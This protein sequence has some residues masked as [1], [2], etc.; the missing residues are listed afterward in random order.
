[1]GITGDDKLLVDRLTI[2]LD[3][4][5]NGVQ[6]VKPWHIN[7]DCETSDAVVI[8]TSEYSG[9]ITPFA[10]TKAVLVSGGKAAQITSS[11]FTVPTGGFAIMFNVDMANRSK[12]NIQVGDEVIYEATFNTIY[13]SAADWKNLQQALGAGPS[14]IINGNITADSAVEGFNASKIANSVPPFFHLY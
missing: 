4:Y 3:G 14:L 9:T 11:P 8:Y 1:M 2:S 5:V 12:A 6:K 13:T 7:H 10:R